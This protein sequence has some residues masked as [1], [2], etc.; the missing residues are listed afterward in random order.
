MLFAAVLERTDDKRAAFLTEACAGDADLRREIESLLAYDD[1]V[2]DFMEM[3]AIDLVGSEAP[4]ALIGR[5]RL[6]EQIGEGGFGAVFLAEQLEPIRRKVALKILKPGLYTREAAARFD[7]ERQAL[8]LLDHPNI[9]KIFDG[10]AT[11]SGRPWFV[12]DLF[13]GMPITQF[14][15]QHCLPS[16]QRLE[17]FVSVCLAV[18]HAHQKGIIHRDLKPSN[19][20]VMMDGSAPAAKVIDFGVAKALEQELTDKTLD[21]GFAQMVGTPLYMSPEQAGA[22]ALDIDTRSDVYSLGVLLYELLTGSTPF[23]S[24]RLRQMAFDKVRRIICEEEPPRPST[25]LSELK[26]SLASISAQRQTEPEKLMNLV[27]G[28]LDW[29]VMKCLEKDRNRRYEAASALAEDIR[30]Y[31]NDEPVL[32]CPP[33]ASYRFRKFSRRNKTALVTAVLVTA[34]LLLGTTVATWQAVRATHARTAAITEKQRADEEAAAAISTTA[35]LQ[36]ILSLM[37]PGAAK[38][39]DYYKV[40]QLLDGYENDLEKEMPVRPES[41]ATVQHAIGRAFASVGEPAKARKHLARALELRRGIFGDHH[42]KYADYLVDYASPDTSDLAWRPDPA[43]EVELRRALTIY[44]ARGVGGRPVLYALRV[45][46]WLLIEEAN[47]SAPEKWR[48]VESIA[49]EAIAETRKLP[50]VEFPETAL[51]LGGLAAAKINQSQYADGE[52]IARESIALRLRLFPSEHYEIGWGYYILANTL[53]SQQKF[54]EALEA[55]MQALAIL[56]KALPPGRGVAQALTAVIRTLSAAADSQ[57]LTHVFP[58]AAELA[59]L[60]SVFLD[61]LKTTKPTTIDNADPAAQAALGLARFTDFYLRL[62]HELASSGRMQEAEQSRQ[63]S[64]AA[65]ASLKA[66]LA[67]NPELFLYA[68][69]GTRQH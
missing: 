18:Q 45:L 69:K 44:R 68:E 19:V 20:L 24:K 9:A 66:Q 14:C 32:A 51:I 6:L 52:R 7:A 41:E 15:D 48:D 3:P 67:G 5:Y 26:E 33:S 64:N 65:S 56:R 1:K 36:R 42:E 40:G 62:C 43:Q 10:G 4:G 60:Q 2:G 16:K 11:A 30:H 55:D 61:V 46:Q 53:R 59:Q 25:R 39:L 37:E 27:R 57:A 13:R 12:M 63:K 34:S 47:Q 35:S 23:D 28:D 50:G 21:T 31:L 22:G 54:K 38:G 49:K 17:V 8:A 29:I 58:S